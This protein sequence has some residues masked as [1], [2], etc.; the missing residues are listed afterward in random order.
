VVADAFAENANTDL[1][2]AMPCPM[3][4]WPW[5]SAP[6]ASRPSAAAI[7]R[8]KTILWNGPMGVFEMKPFQAGHRGRRAEAVAEATQARVRSPWW[9]AAI[10]WPR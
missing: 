6:R 3:V 8:S 9:A 10:A 7:L 4:G 1:C 2:A 5:T